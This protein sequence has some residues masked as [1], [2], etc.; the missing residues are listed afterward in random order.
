MF[1]AYAAGFVSGYC[2]ARL[3]LLWTGSKQAWYVRINGQWVPH[4]FSELIEELHKDNVLSQNECC[5][6]EML[7]GIAI[8]FDCM[9]LSEDGVCYDLLRSS[10][11]PIG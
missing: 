10:R 3:I 9:T 8:N 7:Y 1:R 6:Y 5:E 2:C 4:R 11:Y